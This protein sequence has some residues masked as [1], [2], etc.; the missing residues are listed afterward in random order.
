MAAPLSGK[1]K[2]EDMKFLFDELRKTVALKKDQQRKDSLS[3]QQMNHKEQTQQAK[4]SSMNVPPMMGQMPKPTNP[5]AGP[6]DKIP[7]L[8]APGEAVIPAKAAQKPENKPLIKAL[9]REGRSDR[10]MSIPKPK[11]FMCG[12]DKVK[13]YQW[14]SPEVS[15]NEVGYH[16]AELSDS[17][18]YGVL[19]GYE[20]GT[21]N[22]YGYS[23]EDIAAINAQSNT[24][25]NSLVEGIKNLFAPTT[26]ADVNKPVEVEVPKLSTNL[27]DEVPVS[28]TGLKTPEVPVVSSPD[29][30]AMRNNNPGN[31]RFGGVY[32]KEKG[33]YE[34]TG[35][36]LEGQ[37]GVDPKTGFAIFPDHESGR[38]ALEKQI[39]LDTQTRGMPLD[40]FISKYAPASDNNDPK[41]YAQ[42]I[43]KELGI[44]PTDKIP[45]DKIPMVADVITRVE[46]GGKY[47]ANA[48]QKAEEVKAKEEEEKGPQLLNDPSVPE[49]M[50]NTPQGAFAQQETYLG[51]IPKT[52]GTEQQEML[53]KQETEVASVPKPET[54]GWT[55]FI[56]NGVVDGLA[57][58]FD[59][60]K[61][62]NKFVAA[63]TSFLKDTLGLEASDAARYAALYYAQRA[64]GVRERGAALYA[65]KY[66]LGRIDKR[67]DTKAATEQNYINKGFTKN[68]QGQW[69][70]PIITAG[71]VREVTFDSG[72]FRNKQI[73]LIKRQNKITG[74]TVWV[75][76]VSGKSEAQLVAEAGNR[77]MVPWSRQYTQEGI[78]DSYRT[79]ADNSGK[80]SE[81]ILDDELGRARDSKTNKANPAR[82]GIPKGREI[83]SQSVSAFK[84]FGYNPNTPEAQ[85]EMDKIVSQATRDMI[86]EKRANPGA[87]I[88]SIE[89]YITKQLL[90]AKTG[91]DNSLFLTDDKKNMTATNKIAEQKDNLENKLYKENPKASAQEINDKLFKEYADLQRQWLASEQLRKKYQSTS[92]DAGFYLFVNDYIKSK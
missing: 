74:D 62:P 56:T 80:T 14:G 2:R 89:P 15:G 55:K 68:A 57:N 1:Q 61:D 63:T 36:Y 78:A 75:D 79:W 53:R 72:P 41:G 42:T 59:T 37:T 52:G 21:T 76:Q 43:A 6:K 50:G 22:A 9:V 19:K 34:D 8:L 88:K 64:I 44:K 58:A 31:L 81:E 46:S 24:N 26:Y 86:A 85:V 35:K 3:K 28:A 87:Q 70:A 83:S 39:V 32:N 67:A 17:E 84:A 47:V 69:V 13:G 18:G 65:G 54:E 60:I 45:A 51:N 40:K 92:K 23:D 20:L 38:S 82:S 71:E 30:V 77:P 5:E 25:S 12:T 4:L 11:G 27:T 90:V 29:T 48:K 66:T 49:F 10:N 91:I 7:A 16:N 33:I 73:N